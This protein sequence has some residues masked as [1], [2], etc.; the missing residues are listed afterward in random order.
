MAEQLPSPP[1][2]HS[3]R[4]TKR[5][6]RTDPSTSSESSLG[7]FGISNQMNRCI[8]PPRP[9]PLET[10]ELTSNG[11][12][13]LVGSFLS[14]AWE[15]M[16]EGN[17]GIDQSSVEVEAV[18]RMFRGDVEDI[19]PTILVVVDAPWTE[20]LMKAGEVFVE[21]LK[22]FVGMLFAISALTTTLQPWFVC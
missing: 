18:Q 21:S 11:L 16:Q 14:K 20:E 4:D 3:E 13:Q 6:R 15:L 9:L 7:V 5:A 2:T 19:Q 8:A 12:T 17:V 22:S 1:T 10:I